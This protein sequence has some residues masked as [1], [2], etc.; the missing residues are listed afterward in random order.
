[1]LIGHSAISRKDNPIFRVPFRNVRDKTCIGLY[2][3]RSWW[4]HETSSSVIRKELLQN[5]RVSLTPQKV[6]D[7]IKDFKNQQGPSSS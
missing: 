3:T 6:R 2:V 1:L 7:I 5:T 4:N